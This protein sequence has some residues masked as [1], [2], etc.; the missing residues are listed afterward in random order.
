MGFPENGIEGEKIFFVMSGVLTRKN[1]I[2]SKKDGGLT[3]KKM[4]ASLKK[5]T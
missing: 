3:W 1:F 5:P 4:C 2:L